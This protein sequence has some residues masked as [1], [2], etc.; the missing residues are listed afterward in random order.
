[1]SNT[2]LFGSQ[3][4]DEGKGKIID[5]LTHD[6]DWVVRY[7]GGNNAGHTVEIED[8]K[9]VLHLTPSGILRESCKCVIGN[10]LVV[11]LIGLCEEL[12][13]LTERNIPLTDRLFISDRAHLVLPYHQALDGAKESARSD[14]SKIGTTKRGIGPAYSDKADRTGLRM[15]D[16]LEADFLDRVRTLATAKNQQL[17]ALGQPPLDV[18]SLL[19]E[20]D[21]AAQQLRPFITDTVPLLHQAM[22]RND[23]ILFEGAQG[24]M[25]DIDF[26]TY[27]YVT[28]SNTGAG[29]VASGAGIPPQSIDRV[30]G[31]VKAYTTRVGGGPF[32]TELTDTTGEHIARVGAEFG[33]TTGR[34]RRCGWFDA[35]VARYACMIGGISEWA[36][37]K[38][39]VLDDLDTIHVCTAY[40]IDGKRIEQMPASLRTFE[41]CTP[42]YEA[43]PGWKTPTTHCTSYDELPQPAKDYV[44]YLEKITGIPVSILS[45]GPKRASTIIRSE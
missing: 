31:I 5:V 21:Q 37:M 23:T 27:P 34:P 15:C 40:E 45:V 1:M 43:I 35:V 41:R 32:P 19:I 6:A 10:G 29:G 12:T 42:I 39:D 25:L 13:E 36:L 24:I 30:I 17:T 38:L 9:F 4:G 26:G 7:Q 18:E 11:D 44:A 8:Q 20:V 14:A 28:S 22:Q 16:L 3:W 2:V 33:A